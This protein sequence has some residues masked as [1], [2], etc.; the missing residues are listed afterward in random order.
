M[1]EADAHG[2][3]VG[4]DRDNADAGPREHF[5]YARAHRAEA[6]D[7]YFANVHGLL[8][9]QAALTATLPPEVLVN[10]S[11]SRDAWRAGLPQFAERAVCHRQI[12]AEP[13]TMSSS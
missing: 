11:G 8:Q 10:V 12:A 3:R 4:F 1:P 9:G 6:N 2:L 5:G 13:S 7:R